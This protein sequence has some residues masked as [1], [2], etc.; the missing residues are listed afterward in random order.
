MEVITMLS[1]QVNQNKEFFYCYDKEMM[2]Y[3]R[4]EKGF[5]Y[6][7]TGLNKNSMDQFWQF[8]STDELRESVNE[9]LESK[10]VS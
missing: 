4:Y 8:N 7:C 5:I 1:K 6:N 2:R 9:F 3:L 10:K